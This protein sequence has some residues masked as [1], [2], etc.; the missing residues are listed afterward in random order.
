MKTYSISEIAERF[1]LQ[2]HTLRFYE[3]EGIIAPQRNEA[4]VRQYTEDDLHHLEMVMCL[5]DTGMSIKDIKRYFDLVEAG[6]STLTERLEI[7]V[8]QRD[9]VLKEIA[10]LKNH[11]KMI[12]FKVGMYQ[13]RCKQQAE[14]LQLAKNVNKM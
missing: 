8:Q 5:K 2:P 13:E 3:K 10:E 7:M 14:A 4:G 9:R 1:D 6:D 12:E 11:L